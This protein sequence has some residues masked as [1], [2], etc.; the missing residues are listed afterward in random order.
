MESSKDKPRD[1]L[2]IRTGQILGT[3]KEITESIEIPEESKETLNSPKYRELKFHAKTIGH[4]KDKTESNQTYLS[5]EL[6]T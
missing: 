2:H 3:Y 5:M 1:K 6:T 4:N